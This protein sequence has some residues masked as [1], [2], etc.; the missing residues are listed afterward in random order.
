V[1]RAEFIPDPALIPAPGAP[2]ETPYQGA[3]IHPLAALGTIALDLVWGVGEAGGTA[4]VVGMVAVPVLM[5]CTATLAFWL[6]LTIQRFVARDTWSAAFAKGLLM[7][8]I[9]G[10]PY[11][12]AGTAVGS[13]MLAWAGLSALGRK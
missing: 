13:V 5:L 12:V 8:I 2:A 3:P 9:A 11:P 1:V 4:T 7:A 10:V 6:T